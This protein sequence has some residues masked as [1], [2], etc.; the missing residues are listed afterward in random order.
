MTHTTYL[1]LQGALFEL[2]RAVR[3]ELYRA[4]QGFSNG[5]SDA[6]ELEQLLSAPL[7]RASK[8]LSAPQQ[9]IPGRTSPTP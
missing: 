4:E 1:E 8:A 2:R 7:A 6:E 3:E 5:I 9:E